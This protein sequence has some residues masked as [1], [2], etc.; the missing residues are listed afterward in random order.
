MSSDPSAKRRRRAVRVG[1]Y[2]VV[3]HI[4]TGG[5]GAVYKA[6]DTTLK[7]EVALKVMPPSM[8]SKPNAVER[9][10]REALHAAKLR[11]ENIVTIYEF[12]QAGTTF[13]LAM[14]FVDGIDLLEYIERKGRLDPEEA[15]LITIQA[16][17]AL[18]HAHTQGIVHRDIKPSNF[19]LTRKGERLI[20]KMSDFGLARMTTEEQTRVTR[21]GTTVGTVDYMAPEQAR[22][23]GSADVR[24]DIYSLGCTLYHM[25]AGKAPFPE[26]SIPER[27]YKHNHEEPVDLHQLNPRVSEGLCA[28]VRRMLA[29]DPDERYPTPAALLKDLVRLESAVATFAG[30]EALAGLA[31]AAGERPPAKKRREPSSEGPLRPPPTTA[32]PPRR[33]GGRRGEPEPVE[34][35]ASAGGGWGGGLHN[36][37]LWFLSGAVVALGAAVVSAVLILRSLSS[38]PSETAAP[39]GPPR[40]VPQLV[41]TGRG[42]EPVAHAPELP[43]PL[44]APP[45]PPR[46][47]WPILYEPSA[48][49]AKDALRKQFLGPWA[50]PAEPGPEVPVFRVARQPGAYASLEAACAAAPADR[51]TVI[52]IEDNGPLFPAPISVTDRSLVIRAA[53]GYRPLLIWDAEPTRDAAP[54]AKGGA[55]SLLTLARGNLAL[56]RL[57]LAGR[58]A[59]A[60]GGVR[61]TLVR[62]TDGD[63][64]ARDCTFSLSGRSPAGLG[65]VRFERGD[66][67][68]PRAGATRCRLSRCVARGRG[69]VALNL[70]SP[71]ADVLLDG[72]LVVG[73]EQPLLQVSGRSLAP[74]VL[75]VLRST[76]VS[77]SSLLRVAP[78]TP[79]D[80]RPELHVHTWD[81]LLAHGGEA[82]APMVVLADRAGPARMKWQ[83]TNSL[84]TG[85]KPLLAAAGGGADDLRAW[86]STWSRTEGD[87]AIRPAWPAA[88]PDDPAAS[89]ADEYRPAPA[90]ASPVGY[91]ATS[92]P[93]PLGCDPAALPP[94]RTDWLGLHKP[95]AKPPR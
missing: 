47:E 24:S 20:V 18:D 19:L 81:A 4:A 63:F 55:P 9:F 32:P 51:L 76:L 43:N 49:L 64:L 41:D 39:A 80:T 84:Y 67:G 33:R 65:A 75:R 68:A 60:G 77:G 89:G 30:T 53:R 1:K 85:W 92:G 44:Q 91:A 28:V 87:L 26:G 38:E 78:A 6:I 16:A 21:D 2:E 25:L 3:A 7:R 90:P 34:R 94:V 59:E 12:S 36:H 56:D 31:L 62:V 37:W 72:C 50:G 73:T 48:P 29:K 10:R 79:A 22:D 69:L 88:L 8:A 5:M 15:R 54:G 61:P 95:S 57:D 40:P 82:G 71:G 86:H 14:E 74:P 46:V 17:H 58:W 11:H 66:A 83:A 45:A 23:A 13:Y 27:L 52:E 42:P 70:D 93:G 35:L